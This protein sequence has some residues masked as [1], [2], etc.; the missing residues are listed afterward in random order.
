MVFTLLF[1]SRNSFIPN[2]TSFKGKNISVV[3]FSSKSVAI[4]NNF[5]L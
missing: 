4:F 1:I 2:S 5:D 3:N